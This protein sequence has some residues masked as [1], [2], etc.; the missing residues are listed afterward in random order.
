MSAQCPD[1]NQAL[2][3]TLDH[4]VVSLYSRQGDATLVPYHYWARG[5]QSASGGP[6]T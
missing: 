5:C 3:G 6:V 4:A 2:V 1:H